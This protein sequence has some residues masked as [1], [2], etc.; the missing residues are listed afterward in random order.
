MVAIHEHSELGPVIADKHDDF[1]T[2]A[3]F[4]RKQKRAYDAELDG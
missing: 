2:E 1:T 3:D 4:T